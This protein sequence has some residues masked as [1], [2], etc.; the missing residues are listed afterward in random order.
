ME[1][2]PIEEFKSF[3]NAS[4]PS[5]TPPR[6]V[7]DAVICSNLE[8]VQSMY[9]K[10]NIINKGLKPSN[11]EDNKK[12]EEIVSFKVPSDILEE[13]E[14]IDEA[15][16]DYFDFMA[17]NIVIKY[18]ESICLNDGKS[19]P[20]WKKPLEFPDNLGSGAR[21]RLHDIAEYFGLASH[22]AGKKPHRRTLI[23][24]KNLFIVK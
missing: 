19:A 24:P 15:N 16:K 7:Q 11:P 20:C 3:I 2:N 1:K 23:Y 6:Q 21:L 9:E 8:Q 22:S 13:F 18:I 14:E 10:Q 4:N 17:Y 12:E 5:V